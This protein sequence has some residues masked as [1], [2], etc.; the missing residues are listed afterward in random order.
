VIFAFFWVWMSMQWRTYMNH[1]TS[2]SRLYHEIQRGAQPMA[3]SVNA[4]AEM[5]EI[6]PAAQPIMP[7]VLAAALP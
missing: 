2:G 1:S 3:H 7:L 4:V 5:E 6:C